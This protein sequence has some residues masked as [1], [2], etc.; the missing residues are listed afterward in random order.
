MI[1]HLRRVYNIDS[2]TDNRR[3]L[4]E[5]GSHFRCNISYKDDCIFYT[6][7]KLNGIQK[8]DLIEFYYFNYKTNSVYYVCTIYH[9]I[10]NKSNKSS[11]GY[12][13]PYDRKIEIVFNNDFVKS[14]YTSTAMP[15]IQI[16]GSLREAK[17]YAISLL[18]REYIKELKF[19]MENMYLL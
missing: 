1:N 10:A 8:C 4:N 3:Y 17:R 18:T 14:H 6:I 9:Y 5:D 7:D 11:H 2:V 12:I 16:N 15:I 19:F 13:Y